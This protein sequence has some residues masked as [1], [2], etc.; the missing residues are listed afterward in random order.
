M[1]NPCRLAPTLRSV[2]SSWL[3]APGELLLFTTNSRLAHHQHPRTRLH[4]HPQHAR[5]HHHHR[6]RSVSAPS[7]FHAQPP[8]LFPLPSYLAARTA[9]FFF[10][11]QGS[12]P[13]PGRP[14]FSSFCLALRQP[15]F[16]S[17]CSALRR[18]PYPPARK[19]TLAQPRHARPQ[20][21][22]SKQSKSTLAQR[23]LAR[24]PMIDGRTKRRAVRRHG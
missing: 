6:T 8:A 16:L 9:F 18:A 11:R 20:A 7:L 14:F 24:T 13:F 3:G 2:R 1:T 5:T 10:L 12:H 23:S 19:N 21:K 22:T 15:I 4:T 17:A